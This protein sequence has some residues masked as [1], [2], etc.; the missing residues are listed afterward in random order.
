MEQ[1]E[2]ARL[3]NAAM[4]EAE[5]VESPNHSMSMS[6][7]NEAVERVMESKL[8]HF[9]QQH[10]KKTEIAKAVVKFN[11]KPKNGISYL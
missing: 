5:A 7:L 1:A 3:K 8:S 10:L 9:S 2:Q 6:T 11:L 4:S